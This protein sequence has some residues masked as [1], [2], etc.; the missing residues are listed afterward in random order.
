V[1]KYGKILIIFLLLLASGGLLLPPDS[2]QTVSVTENPI[3]DFPVTT[4][5][6]LS[7]DVSPNARDGH[8]STLRQKE[9]LTPQLPDPPIQQ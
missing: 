9:R 6:G 2:S 4:F 8:E 1:R 3:S 5:T 7:A